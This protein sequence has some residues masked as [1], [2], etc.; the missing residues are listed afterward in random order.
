MP[1]APTTIRDE[2]EAWKAFLNTLHTNIEDNQK[3]KDLARFS[4]A[5]GVASCIS[6]VEDALRDSGNLSLLARLRQS[7]TP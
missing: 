2:W 6:Q 3:M 4:F 1:A 5:D 7:I